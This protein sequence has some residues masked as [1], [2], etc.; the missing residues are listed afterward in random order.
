MS[1]LSLVTVNLIT[2]CAAAKGLSRKLRERFSMGFWDLEPM[3]LRLNGTLLISAAL[4]AFVAA[5][6]SL[7]EGGCDLEL[8]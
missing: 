2:S 5:I 7:L 1:R 8:G 6:G 4:Y 3:I